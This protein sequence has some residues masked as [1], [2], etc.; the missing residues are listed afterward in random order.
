MKKTKVDCC[1]RKQPEKTSSVDLE[2]EKICIKNMVN[3]KKDINEALHELS[4]AL[5]QKCFAKSHP[6]NQRDIDAL[7]E[8]VDM[9]ILTRDVI[10]D[11]FEPYLRFH[12][13]DEEEILNWNQQ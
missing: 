6:E 5:S 12:N 4:S 1:F 11:T 9:L 7:S 2:M 3:A 13:L 10:Q 8:S